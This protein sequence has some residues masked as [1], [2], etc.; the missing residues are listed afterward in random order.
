MRT[1]RKRER[2]EER[3]NQE[4]FLPSVKNERNI[5]ALAECKRE[6]Q[7]KGGENRGIQRNHD[8]PSDGRDSAD[9]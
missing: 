4:G 3:T 7:K 8:R 2:E 9:K 1:K 6:L 5:P